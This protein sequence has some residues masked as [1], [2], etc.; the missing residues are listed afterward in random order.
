MVPEI[1]GGFRVFCFNEPETTKPI[2][3]DDPM[4]TNRG[5]TI[6]PIHL[7][8]DSEDQIKICFKISECTGSV[9]VNR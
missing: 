4:A 8:V 1:S 7:K 2:L 5:P 6:L 3:S 9:R